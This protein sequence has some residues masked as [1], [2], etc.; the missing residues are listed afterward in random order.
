MKTKFKANLKDNVAAATLLAATF[1]AIMGSI[2]TSNDAS[3]NKVVPQAVVQPMEMQYMETIVVTAPRIA[4]VVRL[5]T[6]MVT[7]SRYV[8]DFAN[9]QVASK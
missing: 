8:D 9:I 2:V 5:E 3:A 4:Q 7:A 1:L 6:I